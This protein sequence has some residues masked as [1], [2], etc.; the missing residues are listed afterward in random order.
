VVSEVEPAVAL[1]MN[2]VWTSMLMNY[3]SKLSMVSDTSRLPVGRDQSRVLP[4]D[5]PISWPWWRD[6]TRIEAGGEAVHVLG[7]LADGLFLTSPPSRTWL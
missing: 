7:A 4:K 6:V 2:S 3:R 5:L 1:S